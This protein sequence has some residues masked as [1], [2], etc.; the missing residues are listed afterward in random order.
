MQTQ[1]SPNEA[2]YWSVWDRQNVGLR[3]ELTRVRQ[4]LNQHGK[5]DNFYNSLASTLN[6]YSSLT[7]RQ[8][9][10]LKRSLTQYHDRNERI[11]ASRKARVVSSPIPTGRVTIVGR[12]VSTKWV[13]NNYGGSLKMLVES[14]QGWRVFGTVPSRLGDTLARNEGTLVGSKVAFTAEI[15]PKEADFGFYA[16]PTGGAVLTDAQPEL[17]K[18]VHFAPIQAD[19]SPADLLPKVSAPVTPKFTGSL[20]AMVAAAGYAQ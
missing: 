1:Y 14:E 11:V 19:I 15:Q 20:S 3:D 8:T 10:A 4:E 17:E 12:V 9:E 5:Q 13:E 16:R 18:P 7:E 6:K 2:G